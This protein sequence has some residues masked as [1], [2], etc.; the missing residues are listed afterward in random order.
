M[1]FFY[2]TAGDPVFNLRV[3]QSSVQM[4]ILLTHRITMIWIDLELHEILCS[5]FKY[6]S[7]SAEMISELINQVKLC[8]VLFVVCDSKF[9]IFGF[10]SDF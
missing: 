4:Q 7:I 6:I 5:M 1:A 8:L 10:C 2:F 9:V 3:E